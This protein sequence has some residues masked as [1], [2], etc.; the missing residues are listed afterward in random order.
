MNRE[1]LNQLAKCNLKMAAFDLAKTFGGSIV[2][3]EKAVALE[4]FIRLPCPETAV[5][6]V[7]VWPKMQLAVTMA[8]DCLASMIP[9]ES[10]GPKLQDVDEWMNSFDRNLKATEEIQA[11]LFQE[12][13]SGSVEVG[14]HRMRD[15]KIL[16]QRLMQIGIKKGFFGDE[17]QF[18]RNRITKDISAFRSVADLVC[19]HGVHE[20][21]EKFRNALGVECDAQL[22][23]RSEIM[24][25]ISNSM[26]TFLKI[27]CRC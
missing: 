22:H 26:S 5:N 20:G 4:A 24:Y 2:K 1:L 15:Q 25:E 18:L 6:L 13:T 10:R 9:K 7:Y 19:L 21:Q 11:H 8:N 17:R 12:A 27:F 14:F 23:L 3:D 16:L